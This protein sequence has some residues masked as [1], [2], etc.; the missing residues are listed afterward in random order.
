[1]CVYYM[2]LAY[3]D[4]SET[5]KKGEPTSLSPCC[6]QGEEERRRGFLSVKSESV[7]SSHLSWWVVGESKE[8]MKE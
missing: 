4:M 3:L 7:S 6:L 2:G 8:K 5:R 1:M